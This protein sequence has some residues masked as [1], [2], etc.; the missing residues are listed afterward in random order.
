MCIAELDPILNNQ[1]LGRVILGRCVCPL[2]SSLLPCPYSTAFQHQ[3]FSFG[4]WFSF[5]EV[6][7]PT[8]CSQGLSEVNR[9]RW[10]EGQSAETA[11]SMQEGDNVSKSKYIYGLSLAVWL[12]TSSLK[13]TLSARPM[14]GW[15]DA[16]SSGN[17][18][19][20]C[21]PERRRD[22]SRRS[23]ILYSDEDMF[24]SFAGCYSRCGASG[25][26]VL[27]TP[28][29]LSPPVVKM[30]NVRR[31]QGCLLHMGDWGRENIPDSKACWATEWDPI[32]L[33]LKKW[34]FADPKVK[35][36]F[37]HATSLRPAW[38]M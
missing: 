19:L 32:I 6:T 5:S 31:S 33:A 16:A 4:L 20:A 25:H 8:G 11:W 12:N 26:H 15:W 38:D 9:G 29:S 22:P 36:L 3:P 10:L 14:W 7:C 35:V 30:L 1:N 28:P 18:I 21:R 2:L 23:S 34:K 17:Y 13:R 37:S 24:T 27:E